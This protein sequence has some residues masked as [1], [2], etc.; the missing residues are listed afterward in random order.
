M[1]SVQK[2]KLSSFRCAA[3]EEKESDFVHGESIPW[4]K[5]GP[6]ARSRRICCCFFFFLEILEN[7]HHSPFCSSSTLEGRI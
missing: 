5:I 2:A 3:R 7:A 4:G 1:I 6:R